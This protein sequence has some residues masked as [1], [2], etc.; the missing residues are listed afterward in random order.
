MNP[1][2]DTLGYGNRAGKPKASSLDWLLE[3]YK[4][5]QVRLP[6]E[7]SFVRALREEAQG[8]RRRAQVMLERARAAAESNERGWRI[9]SRRGTRDV[10]S[11]MYL[12]MATKEKKAE[13]AEEMG[14]G[15]DD[16]STASDKGKN[17]GEEDGDDDDDDDDDEDEE[18]DDDDEEEEKDMLGVFLPLLPSSL[19]DD[20]EKWEAE[21]RETNAHVQAG[22][23]RKRR[24]K[25]RR[26][27]RGKASLLLSQLLSLV[28]ELQ[29]SPV[30][31]PGTS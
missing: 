23:G 16:S 7:R 5:I 21:A 15:S 12:E 18:N 17:T 8:Q 13:E 24:R 14:K 10:V 2:A 28:R 29:A 19:V 26:R 22:G 27:R 31:C 9:W 6:D 1:G 4:S 11:V 3:R 30:S 25:R 20:E